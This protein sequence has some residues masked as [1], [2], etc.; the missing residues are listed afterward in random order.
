M[1]VSGTV[2]CRDR[3]LTL[4]YVHISWSS[5]TDPADWTLIT[6]VLPESRQGDKP[7]SIG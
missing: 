5:F 1:N 7:E 6:H 3:P 2:A 4:A